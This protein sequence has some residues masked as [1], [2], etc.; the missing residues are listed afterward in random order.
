MSVI[1]WSLPSPFKGC[2]ITSEMLERNYDNDTFIQEAPFITP[3]IRLAAKEHNT[4]VYE[5][6][7]AICPSKHTVTVINKEL[8][9]PGKSHSMH[10]RAFQMETTAPT[11]CQADCVKFRGQSAQKIT[12]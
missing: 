5:P 1:E 10:H 8:K 9:V 11:S 3:S 7:V 2:Y 6:I 12:N 4:N